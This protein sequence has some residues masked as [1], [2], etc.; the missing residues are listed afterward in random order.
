MYI[1]E[2]NRI[3]NTNELTVIQF[4][5]TAKKEQKKKKK[6]KEEEGEKNEKKK[7]QYITVKRNR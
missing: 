3:I 7:N 6:E 5:K 4:R 2:E 1:I